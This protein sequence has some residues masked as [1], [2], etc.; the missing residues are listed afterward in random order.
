MKND[1]VLSEWCATLRVASRHTARTY[2]QS[3]RRFLR[4]SGKPLKRLGPRDASR[5]APALA[6]EGLSRATI[7]HHVSAVRSFI[8]YGQDLGA[9][10]PG[11]LPLLKRPRV[12]ETHLNRFLRK[13]EAEDLLAAAA[14]MEASAHLG[15]LLML[16]TGVR[17]AELAQAEWRHLFADEDGNIGLLIYGKGGKERIVAVRPEVWGRLCVDRR[18]R[19]LPSA[20]SG[21]DATPLIVSRRGAR[22]TSSGIWK[23]V[24]RVARRSGLD[25]P[26]SPHWL[27][28]TFGTLAAYGG[29]SPFQIQLDM[30]H[31]QLV[32]SQRYIHVAFA[33]SDGAARYIDLDLSGRRHSGAA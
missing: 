33:L 28:H 32:T 4:A 8:R 29:A 9:I 7:A 20:L 27:R 11:V 17:V 10:R 16:T 18:R 21:T 22:Y 23:M 3:V 15:I 1:Q 14:D 5:Y 2:E 25:K 24:R 31:A 6:E 30:G 19:D 12:P 26:V 13:A